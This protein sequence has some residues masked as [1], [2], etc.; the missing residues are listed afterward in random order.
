M[1]GLPFLERLDRR[2]PVRRALGQVL[3]VEPDEAGQRRLQVVGAVESMRLQHLRQSPV[4]ALH[5]AVG[6]RMLGLGQLVLDTQCL[7]Q[8][9]ELM[10]AAGVLLAPPEGPVGELPAVVRQQRLDLERRGPVQGIEER[11]RSSC[12]LLALDGDEHPPRGSVDR[13]EDISSFGFVLHLRQIL[14]VHVDVARFIGF[15]GLDLGPLDLGFRQAIDATPTQKPVQRRSAHVAFDELPNHSQQVVQ[16]KAQM[17][18]QVDDDLFLA[19]V[20]RCLQPMRRVAAVFDRR[21]LGS[22]ADGELAHA[23]ALC[24]LG[25]GAMGLLDRQPCGRHGRGV[26]VQADQHRG[27]HWFKS[28]S[29]PFRTCR[30]ARIVYRPPRSHSSGTRQLK[31]E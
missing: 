6:L 5:H 11:A 24:Q 9:I 8:C 3:V 17:R 23:E 20:Q 26:L 14:H 2:V 30:P 12:G 29:R 18:A 16:R 21:A 22:L 28:A 4:E 13:Y 10:F 1:R 31:S 19:S 25:L 15:E 7:A 27:L